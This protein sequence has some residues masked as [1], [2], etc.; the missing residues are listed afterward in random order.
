MFRTTL[1]S[2]SQQQFY[3]SK[4][5]EDGPQHTKDYFDRDH[6]QMRFLRACYLGDVP[7]IRDLIKQ[8]NVNFNKHYGM[9]PLLLASIKPTPRRAEV[10]NILLDH[11]ATQ[12]LNI[13]P[14]TVAGFL[15]SCKPI[16]KELITLIIASDP[17]GYEQNY[18]QPTLSRKALKFLQNQGLQYR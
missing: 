6:D 11:G 12:K 10:I 4:F 2:F 15:L 5:F 7:V 9:T 8:V 17:R 16:D 1:D 14:Y 3:D 18:F 13:H